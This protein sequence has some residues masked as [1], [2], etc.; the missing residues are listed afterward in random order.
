MVDMTS[1]CASNTHPNTILSQGDVLPH[2]NNN[3]IS[4]PLPYNPN[5]PTDPNLWDG[6][7]HLVSLHRSLEHLTLDAKNIKD[8]LNFMAKYIDNKQID[9]SKSNDVEDLK[10]I[11]MAIWNF[12]SSVYQF[13]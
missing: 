9:P 8:F 5:A 11:G 2:S 1:Q 7:F 10:G 12:I 4:V 13:K 3:V 6:S